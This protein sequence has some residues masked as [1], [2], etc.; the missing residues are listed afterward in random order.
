MDKIVLS[1]TRRDVIG[2]KVK[3]LRNEGKLPAVIY[4]KNVDAFPILLD[5][6]E[7]SKLLRGA[8]RASVLTIDVEGE[9]FPALLRERQRDILSG[10]YLH[11][12]FLAI[13]LTETVRTLVN[14]VLKGDSPAVENFEAILISG[15]DRVEVESLPGDLP[16]SIIVDVSL[17]ETIGDGVY[18]K[19]LVLSEGVEILE[20]P[21]DMI[22]VATAPSLAEEEEEVE[23]I[24]DEE[25]DEDGEPIVIEKGKDEGEEEE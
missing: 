1:A 25:F 2:K 15:L 14:I 5:M 4:G 7:T 3:V 9:E 11:I 19:D 10:Q 18:V 22:V 13:S 23:E 24:L 17:I 21:R 8:T 12:D 16:E 6:R 20:D